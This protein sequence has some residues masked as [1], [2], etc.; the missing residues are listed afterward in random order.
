[1]NTRIAPMPM[2]IIPSTQDDYKL[3][4]LPLAERDER[5]NEEYDSPSLSTRDRSDRKKPSSYQATEGPCEP[6]GYNHKA[7]I[8]HS[9][10]ITAVISCQ[11]VSAIVISCCVM[12]TEA[13]TRLAYEIPGRGTAVITQRNERRT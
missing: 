11:Q 6:G 13:G 4:R 5:T 10:F 3:P 1:M 2:V 12:L 8:P 7:T 9:Q